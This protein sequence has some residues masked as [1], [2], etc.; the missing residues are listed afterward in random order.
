MTPQDAETRARDWCDAWNRRDLDAV[1][2]H[3]AED[4]TIRSPL[5][6]QRV[7]T[8]DGVLQGKAA[9]RAYFAICMRNPALS[10]S[11]VA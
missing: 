7:G 6:A 8:P 1:L 10:F 4:V 9:L 3:Y 5:V 11:L 2:D